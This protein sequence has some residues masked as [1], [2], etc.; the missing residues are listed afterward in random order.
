MEEK[1]T[2]IGFIEEAKAEF[3]AN[4]KAASERTPE[5]VKEN[6]E[7]SMGVLKDFYFAKKFGEKRFKFIPLSRDKTD[8]ELEAKAAKFKRFFAQRLYTEIIHGSEVDLPEDENG[9]VTLLSIEGVAKKLGKP[10]DEVVK[11]QGELDKKLGSN[12]MVFGNSSAMTSRSAGG[13]FCYQIT[14]EEGWVVPLDVADTLAP[15]HAAE[16]S[17]DATRAYNYARNIYSIT[18]FPDFFATYCA[19][20]FD[21]PIQAL[22]FLTFNYMLP[23]IAGVWYSE[24]EAAKHVNLDEFKR[25]A[26]PIRNLYAQHH[27]VPPFSPEWQYKDEVKA[28]KVDRA[29]LKH[30]DKGKND[31]YE[32][33]EAVQ[34]NPQKAK[35]MEANIF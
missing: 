2:E 21:S 20:V 12:S 27:I 10:V 18:D 1:A 5:T 34:L 8:K 29:T 15:S 26:G 19:T 3:D 11:H 23:Q 28:K 6:F 17:S 9:E 13:K 35:R 22:T 31:L 30:A 4:T 24:E 14:S 32:Y 25:F 7:R 16:V 33:S